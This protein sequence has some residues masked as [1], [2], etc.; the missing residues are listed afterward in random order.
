MILKQRRN[1]DL[2]RNQSKKP[3]VYLFIRK[4]NMAMLGRIDM[5]LIPTYPQQQKMTH[6]CNP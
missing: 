2:L 5:M 4:C 6:N 1:Q 3:M